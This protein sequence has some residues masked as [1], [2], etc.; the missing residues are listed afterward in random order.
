MPEHVEDRAV[1]LS[2]LKRA[3]LEIREMRAQLDQ[4]ETARSEPIAVI[5]MGLRFPGGVNSPEAYWSLLRNG[6]DAIQDIP[7][8]RWD[9]HALYDADP[10]TP[11]KMYTRGGGFLEK[12]DQFDPAFFGI[13]PREAV[14][15]D[16]QQRL[17]LEVT[18]EA[19][20]RA[21]QSPEKLVGSQTGVFIGIAN[22][23]YGRMV[24]A[25]SSG[26]DMYAATGTTFSVASGRLSYILGLQGPSVSLDTACSSSLVAV[27]LAVQSLRSGE[28]NLALV[29]GS[30]LMLTPEGHI[31]FSK[32][33]VMAFDDRC[34]TFDAAADGY[35]R[36]EGCG[37]IV[38]KR[39]SDAQ[40]HGDNILALI[41]GSGVNQDGRS[42]GLTAPNGPS[43]EAVL[44]SALENAGITP[45]LVGYVEA[46]GTGTPLGDP[47]E[48][49]ALAAVLGEGHDKQYPLLIGSV[50]TNFG[51]LEAAAGI[52]GLMKIVLML[53]HHEIVPHLH[54]T[55]P[56]P[57]IPWNE[58]PI[59]VTTTLRPFPERSGRRIAGVSSF[60]FSGTNSHVILEST[61]AI[62]SG[63]EQ[64]NARPMHLLTVSARRED[65][66]LELARQYALRLEDKQ[67]SFNDFCFTANTGRAHL[68][69]RL[70]V[71]A[72][73]AS[74]ARDK[75]LS[76]ISHQEMS[77]VV[78][79]SLVDTRP[80]EIAL[81]FTGHGAQYKGMGRVLYE[82]QPTFRAAIDECA[83]LLRAYYDVPLHRILFGEDGQPSLFDKMIYAQPA[84]F[85]LEY[86]LAKMWLS[87][88]VRPTMVMG[89]SVGEYAAACIAGLFSVADGLKL[90]VT[91]GRLFD[92]L[93]EA[94]EMVAVFADETTVAAAIAPY[95]DK[96]SI[97][98][99]NGPT[100]IVISGATE[101]V[102]II[103][104]HLKAQA[105]KSRKLDVPQSSHSPL[106][107]PILDEFERVAAEVTYYPPQIGLISDV[108]GE[109]ASFDEVGN[110][111]YWRRHLRQ[112]VQFAAAMET[113]RHE[114]YSVFI[115]I[116]P[117]PTLL[118]MGRRCLPSDYGVWLPSLRQDWNDWTQVLESLSGLYVNGL[119]VD[120]TSFDHDYS[121]KRI[122][123]PTYPWI[124]ERY[125]YEGA[126]PKQAS[127]RIDGTAIWQGVVEAGQHQAQQ[128]PL[129][130]GLA[131]YPAKWSALKRLTVTYIVDTLQ[132]YG[133]FT[134][135]GEAYTVEGL[136]EQ[137]GVQPGYRNLVYRWL[138]QLVE[139]GLL[140]QQNDN[141]VGAKP[142]PGLSLNDGWQEVKSA[143][144]DLPSLMDYLKRCGD[145]LPQILRGEYS[146][147]ETL[148]PGGS[149]V[150]TDF[151]YNQWALVR[152]FNAIARSVIAAAINRLNGRD[153]R[154]LEIGAGTGGL[155]GAI[156]PVFPV[157]RT[158]Y[159]YTD[160]SDFF[161]GRAEEKFKVYPFVHYGLLNIE[162]E[163]G[164][165]GYTPHSFDFI[166]AANSL[167][168]TRDLGQTLEHVRSL[169]APNGLL[170]VYE[171]TKHLSFYDMTT[172]LIEGWGRFEDDLRDDNPLLKAEDWRSA[173][174]AHGF[175]AAIAFPEAGS[176]SEIFGQH[177]I[178]G[179]AS[180][181]GE[182]VE[183]SI[184]HIDV[185]GAVANEA[186][187][188][189]SP[190]A[191]RNE[192][193]ALMPEDRQEQVA[194]FVRGRV[195]RT[196][197]LPNSQTIDLRQRLMDM[198]LDSL[199]A[200]ELR[201]S[202]DNGL[203]LGGDLP[204][205]LIF[206]YPTIEAIVNYLEAT[207]FTTPEAPVEETSHIAP[208]Q[209]PSSVDLEALSDDEVA[210][211]LMKK[212]GDI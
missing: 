24:W 191:F 29:G 187:I 154:V 43:Q 184:Q 19:L 198:G 85:A 173:M 122:I 125:W 27:H 124:R 4:Y 185:Q 34:K 202:L 26:M 66:L 123:L 135:A 21:G 3:L 190:E 115:E 137:A 127:R 189:V 212:L 41:L 86:G 46:H 84:L 192:L 74:D 182:R 188:S 60:G 159:Y 134:Q 104:A 149:F 71:I 170:I 93:T 196:L 89:H 129:D 49:Q 208:P 52:A 167:H 73:S 144:A 50:K 156:L 12:I 5:G 179:Q 145:H 130:L 206:D 1:E 39:L 118:G 133:V 61:S 143:L 33:Q 158:T 80:P 178:V 92:S 55:N 139:E 164:I 16:P 17:L 210:A 15:M 100:N 183:V 47:I 108:T 68:T 45:D 103:V 88:G 105:I 199:M 181:T 28:T 18:W 11:G 176:P 7:A 147:L 59:E 96:V 64:K 166:L 193:S 162:Q 97:G 207:V 102:Q 155:S 38:L 120:W 8:D 10:N 180:G 128:A 109:M 56:N 110:A 58:I 95:A 175:Q 25:D 174:Q 107:E 99:I 77:G 153:L 113:L 165:Q 121:P 201:N 141:F 31:T 111:A 82:T 160:V 48:V 112:P 91:R 72:E 209:Q 126:E 152:Y 30:N 79:R 35:V 76:F 54:F 23:D 114:N 195:A 169:L 40:A 172:G 119:D 161:L 177:I 2:P 9:M 62:E 6:I 186:G 67:I 70:A 132:Q 171:T 94:G 83:E 142:L 57:Y 53:Q 138:E 211:L 51:H 81:L 168:A 63:E 44:R 32:G 42:S 163:P 20:E 204:A 65:V 37:M 150:T 205:T 157:D 75:L 140:K 151:I 101:T 136:M 200:V 90:V 194:A 87:W 117:N 98:A 13:S 22:S 148:F 146:P 14:S 203:G 131:T 69:R 78:Y 197:R 116:G 106:L 36:G